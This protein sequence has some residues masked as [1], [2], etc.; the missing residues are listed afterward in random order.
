MET[1]FKGEFY[2]VL[3]SPSHVPEMNK[4]EEV[5]GGLSVGAAVTLNVLAK[6]LKQLVDKLPG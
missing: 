2:E 3:I 1:K 4:M 6:K 5:E